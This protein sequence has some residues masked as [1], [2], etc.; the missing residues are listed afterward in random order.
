M[1]TIDDLNTIRRNIL[2]CLMEATSVPKPTYT[3]GG[4][5]GSQTVSWNE[6]I[7]MLTEQLDDIQK[8]IVALSP[9]SVSTRIII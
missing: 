4:P 1:A 2:A 3:I 8:L 5:D 6:Y 7:R 9:Y